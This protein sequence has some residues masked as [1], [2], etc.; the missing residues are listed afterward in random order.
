MTKLPLDL[1]E[2]NTEKAV[3]FAP[4]VWDN[5][6]ALSDVSIFSFLK[7]KRKNRS[8][9]KTID[10]KILSLAMMIAHSQKKLDKLTVDS[11][12]L[13]TKIAYLNGRVADLKAQYQK[14][15][16][17]LTKLTQSFPDIAT[18]K[19]EI[20]ETTL[21]E[22]ET[23]YQSTM[24]T[25][26]YLLT[27]QLE[28][29][30]KEDSLDARQ[31]EIANNSMKVVRTLKSLI[32]KTQDYQST[33]EDLNNKLNTISK[34]TINV[35]KNINACTYIFPTLTRAFEE[36]AKKQAVNDNFVEEYD[37][38]IERITALYKAN[39]S[40]INRMEA[41][42]ERF[43]AKYE[44]AQCYF[45]Q[46]QKELNDTVNVCDRAARLL[47]EY[48]ELFIG[49]NFI[50]K[51]E[52]VQLN[53]VGCY[54]IIN[55]YLPELKECPKPPV[56]PPMAADIKFG[57]EDLPVCPPP[58]C[59][60]TPAPTFPPTT[61]Q[62]PECD[63][64]ILDGNA[65]RALDDDLDLYVDGKFVKTF[66][67][68]VDPSTSYDFKWPSGTHTFEFKFKK[69]N[70]NNTV[71]EITLKRKSD[72]KQIFY[73]TVSCASSTPIGKTVWSKTVNLTC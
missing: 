13:Q 58:I 16:E 47:D 19:T 45:E 67:G 2:V 12:S 4:L 41:S 40:M 64:T 1:I 31:A 69:S 52:N 26:G 62:P 25:M 71:K 42:L 54:V 51:G 43:G 3:D 24:D 23:N 55:A 44:D 34:L 11:D 21:Y 70:N 39:V 20:R 46:K 32:T 53:R 50:K 36:L 68:S 5:G 33:M 59:T 6:V 61:T 28:A 48:Y 63:F 30:I 8:L 38:L 72:G 37:A 66:V 14:Y 10:S 57:Q 17:V 9:A 49:A 73:E 18:L 56:L 35:E 22:L 29:S 65:N 15:I 27:R 60:T 7:E